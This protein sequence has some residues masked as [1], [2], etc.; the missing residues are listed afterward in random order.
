MN[1]AINRVSIWIITTMPLSKG[2]KIF[3]GYIK[4]CN[5]NALIWQLR[6]S[7]NSQLANID[8]AYNTAFYFDFRAFINKQKDVI[9]LTRRSIDVKIKKLATI[10]LTFTIQQRYKTVFF[11]KKIF[12]FLL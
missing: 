2:A 11:K 5:I 12:I 8:N 6:D 7:L 10:M 3:V 4:C 1:L 9:Y